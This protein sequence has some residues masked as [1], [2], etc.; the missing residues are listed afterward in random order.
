MET[1]M[2]QLKQDEWPKDQEPTTEETQVEIAERDVRG[3]KG[4]PHGGDVK[5]NHPGEEP[6]DDLLNVDVDSAI[7]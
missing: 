5:N 6:G 2:D 3:S 1:S 4:D 7:D